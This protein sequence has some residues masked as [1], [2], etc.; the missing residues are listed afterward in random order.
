MNIIIGERIFT[1]TLL[2]I[3]A[4]SCDKFSLSYPA[5]KEKWLL[6]TA[7]AAFGTF[8]LSKTFFMNN[9]GKENS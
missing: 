7:R 2:L 4:N 8:K 3:I 5:T 9:S 1:K 6:L